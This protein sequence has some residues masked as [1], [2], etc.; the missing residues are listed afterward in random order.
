MKKS[1]LKA[2]IHAVLC[3]IILAA[4]NQTNAQQLDSNYYTSKFEEDIFKKLENSENVQPLEILLGIEHSD[5]LERTVRNELEM[6]IHDIRA[7]GIESKKTKKQIQIIYKMVHERMLDQYL[8]DAD[9][10]QIFQKG[11]YNCASASALYALIFDEF[12]IPYQIKELP[13]HVYIVGNPGGKEIMV[14]STD[15]N[16]GTFVI[17][18]KEKERIVRYLASNKIIGRQEYESTSPEMLYEKYYNTTKNINSTELAALIYY[19]KG[20]F[21]YQ[22]KAY[23][24]HQ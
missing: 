9:F 21:N 17:D 23:H 7:I 20:V 13:S 1:T 11:K 15:P 22:K 19:N 24:L 6:L 14:E 2:I 12:K 4:G 5:Q 10:N 3:S 8:L 16:K 18:L